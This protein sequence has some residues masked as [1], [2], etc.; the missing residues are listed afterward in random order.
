MQLVEHCARKRFSTN[1][2]R[3][4]VSWCPGARAEEGIDIRV[5]RELS[6]ADSSVAG[7]SAGVRRAGSSFSM[8]FSGIGCC[9]ARP[10]GS[11]TEAT[12]ILGS[13]RT[14]RTECAPR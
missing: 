10:T 14:V 2:N 13:L 9:S 4:G 8:G 7:R 11:E 5:G 1:A 3:K 12:A 6:N